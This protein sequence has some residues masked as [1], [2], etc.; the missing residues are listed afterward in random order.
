MNKSI[1]DEAVYRIAP[2]TPGLLKTESQTWGRNAV[3]KK[4]RPHFLW[5][6]VFSS[7][8]TKHS[9]QKV[10][11][12]FFFTAFLPHVWDGFFLELKCL[13]YSRTNFPLFAGARV[14]DTH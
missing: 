7:S 8:R 4:Q 13:D 1:N 14:L 3:K 2:A 12:Q 5:T 9:P 11:T 6:L 10:R